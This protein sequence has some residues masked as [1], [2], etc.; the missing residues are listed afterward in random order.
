[1][2][3]PGDYRAQQGHD[4]ARFRN[5]CGE[6]LGRIGCHLHF[7]QLPYLSKIS[8]E[9]KD[10]IKDPSGKPVWEVL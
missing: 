1:M 3:R 8:P 7:H 10:K 4:A 9:W 6:P 5:H 2:E